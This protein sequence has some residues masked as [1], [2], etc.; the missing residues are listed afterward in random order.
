MSNYG[1]FLTACLQRDA[2]GLVKTRCWSI[3][4]HFI[5]SSFVQSANGCPL[6]GGILLHGV[7]WMVQ[8]LST[9]GICVC[10]HAFCSRIWNPTVLPRLVIITLL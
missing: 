1:S 8:F 10:R 4:V 9:C 2:V 5:L 7:E 3:I 6:S